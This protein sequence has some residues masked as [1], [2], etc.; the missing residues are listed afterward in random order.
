[1]AERGH[2]IYGTTTV[3]VS[4][5]I[6]APLRYVFEWSTDYRED[7]GQLSARRPRP[8]FRVVRLSARRV[9]RIRITPVRGSDPS[10]AVDLVRLRPPRS[11]HTDQIDETDRE[12]VDYRL[13]SLGR[14]RTRIELLVTERW[15]TPE[16][17]TARQLRDRV[18][19]A[20][21]RYGAAIEERF[22]AGRP[23][24]G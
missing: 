14:S 3:R 24:K 22:R 17:P 18:R 1:V 4:K 9:L 10:V 6:E 5:L 13:T 20:W 23:A 2:R 12:S 15:L 11:W 16:Y 19:G 7:D 21:D 8:R